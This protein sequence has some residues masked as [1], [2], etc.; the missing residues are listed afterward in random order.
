MSQ[1]L[2]REFMLKNDKGRELYHKYAEN[3]PIIDYHC[4][5]DPKEIFEDKPYEN[6]TEMW[7]KA[8]HYKWRLMREAGVPEEY[9]TGSMTDHDKFVAFSYALKSAIGN[10]LHHWSHMELKKYFGITAHLTNES[11]ENIWFLT[12]TYLRDS[13]LS[14]R[15]IIEMSN[16]EVVCTTDDPIDSLIWHEK[17]KEDTTFRVKVLPAFRPDRAVAI[18]KDDFSEYVKKLSLVSEVDIS[19]FK[20]LKEAL[21]NRMEYFDCHGCRVSDHGLQYIPYMEADESE[22]DAIL[23]RKL[24]GN[25]LTDTE[26]E[27]YRTAV[28]LFLSGE[29]YERDWVMQLHFGVERNINSRMYKALSADSGFDVIS[30]DTKAGNLSKFLDRV[31][32]KGMPKTVVYSLNPND[33]ALID[34]VINSFQ[35]ELRGKMQHGAAWWF[36]DSKE[37][38]LSQLKS[39]SSLGNLGTFIGMLTDSRSFT[40]YV[41]HD[42]FRRILCSYIGGLVEDGEYPDDSECLKE[43]IEGISYYNAKEYFGF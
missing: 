17:I 26:C 3:L 12:E 2:D 13:A 7:L 41:R 14:P 5:I 15:K 27:K 19:D 43:I 24:E 25:T 35:G 8:D 23:M 28:L 38:I 29:Y 9:I 37:G 42:Y 39:F 20:S 18:E 30:A 33:N 21:R 40:S 32:E 22:I 6:I 31:N 11:A 34:T 10:P 36:N 4:H 16:V 1:F